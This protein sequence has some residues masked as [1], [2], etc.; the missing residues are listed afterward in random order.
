MTRVRWGVLSTAGIGTRHVIP[1]M[2]RGTHSTVSAIASRDLARAQLVAAKFGIAAAHGSYE[3]LLADRDVDA[4]YIPLPNH[5]HV[6]WSV[7]ALDAGKH[8]LCEKPIGLDAAE[9]G[10]LAAAAARHRSLKVMEA[11]MYRL[12]PQWE[13]AHALVTGGAIGEVRAV[14]TAFAYF[15]VDP[16]N[17][18]NQKDIGGG[19]LM[20]IGCYGV[21]LSRFLFGREPVRAF[22]VSDVDPRFGTDRL[23]T[24]I[25][26]FG[27]GVGTFTCSTQLAPHQRVEILGADGRID[28][29][30]P[31][32]APPDRP[33]RLWLTRGGNREE[34]IFDPCNQYTIQGDRFSLAVL[35]DTPVPTPIADAVANMRVI[36]AIR[37]AG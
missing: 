25:L 21:S 20:D 29:D 1:A 8:V 36:D 16:Q 7:R 17:V 37:K 31:F 15:N 26:D 18:R 30:V 2:Q 12:H 9:A 3:A 34:V 19:A 28:I 10:V 27:G 4:V 13:R 24:A 11:F 23:T 33:S 14:Q 35:H 5:L 22:G 32:N 6:P